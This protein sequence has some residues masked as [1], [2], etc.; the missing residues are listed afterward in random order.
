MP[1]SRRFGSRPS[2]STRCTYSE[3]VSATSARSASL[4]AAM[5]A[6][7]DAAAT[8]ITP[9]LLI[10]FATLSNSRIPSDDPSNG[11]HARSGCG[12]IPSTLR[13]SLTMPAMSCIDPFGDV[14]LDRRTILPHI[15]KRHPLLALEHVERLVISNEAPLPMRHRNLQDIPPRS[16]PP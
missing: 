16:T 4:A 12:I 5:H 2:D 3:R 15:P 1:S 10:D 8:G 11:S 7:H 14:A 13:R 6:G 9:L